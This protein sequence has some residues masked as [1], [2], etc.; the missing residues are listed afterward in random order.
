MTPEDIKEKIQEYDDLIE[1]KMKGEQSVSSNGVSVTN[2]SLSELV[3][4]K[5]HLVASLNGSYKEHYP[6]FTAE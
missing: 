4:A 6:S 1:A 5:N 2:Y 3:R